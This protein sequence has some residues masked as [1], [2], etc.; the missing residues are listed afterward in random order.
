MQHNQQTTFRNNEKAS[1]H[2]HDTADI[3]LTHGTTQ[4]LHDQGNLTRIAR[5]HLQGSRS[6]G[7]RQ[8]GHQD[9][10]RRDGWPQLPE[11]HSYPQSCGRNARHT[12]GVLHGLRR[13]PAGR[14]QALGDHPHSRIRLHRCL[15]PDGRI[16]TDAYFRAR[17]EAPEIR[18][19]R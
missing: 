12:R 17:Q 10:F 15:R 8:S 18:H 4:G 3:R 14:E 13:Q 19:R 1:I 11:A 7:T 9:Q 2:G 6:E 5:A 16:R